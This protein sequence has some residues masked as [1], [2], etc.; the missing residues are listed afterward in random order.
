M[1][2]N[3]FEENRPS[4]CLLRRFNNTWRA[5]GFQGP[6]IACTNTTCNECFDHRDLCK[7]IANMGNT[8]SVRSSQRRLPRWLWPNASHERNDYRRANHVLT[9]LGL[10]P[11]FASLGQ[12]CNRFT[13]DQNVGTIRMNDNGSQ[14]SFML[15]RRPNQTR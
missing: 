14:L 5:C 12:S 6:V 8:I 11:N 2:M 3:F 15:G 10:T 9:I 13:F 1:K 7:V 4:P